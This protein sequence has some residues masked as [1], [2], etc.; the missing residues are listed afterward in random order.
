MDRTLIDRFTALTL[1]SHACRMTENRKP[2][3]YHDRFVAKL[4]SPTYAKDV[5]LGVMHFIYLIHA[6]HSNVYKIGIAVDVGARFE[7][8][9][10][11]NF[12]ELEVVKTWPV[13]EKWETRFAERNLHRILSDC[14]LR[15]EWFVLTPEQV[16]C[17]IEAESIVPLNKHN[18]L[19]PMTEEE[20]AEYL[21]MSVR[22]D[23][24]IWA[25]M[26]WPL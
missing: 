23:F 4:S 16:K 19:R 9:Q 21:E 22:G 10:G 26:P 2:S 14:H 12:M 25:G 17:F 18:P 7:Q 24:F 15:G 1:D 6:K 5:L 8:L 13:G 11:A 20:E 3:D